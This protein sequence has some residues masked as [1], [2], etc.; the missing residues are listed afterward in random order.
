MARIK[1]ITPAQFV[2]GKATRIWEKGQKQ[3][4]LLDVLTRLVN[5]EGHGLAYGCEAQDRQLNMCSRRT[6]GP[7]T[8]HLGPHMSLGAEGQQVVSIWDGDFCG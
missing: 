4:P 1:K 6:T 3:A 2:V 5:E 7:H 8:D